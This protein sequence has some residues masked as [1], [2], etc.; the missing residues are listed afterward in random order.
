[1]IRLGGWHDL[2]DFVVVKMGDFD[3]VLGIEYLLGH[4]VIR[5]PL[6][7]CLV[8]TRS[9]PTIV[10]TE[11]HQPNGQTP[12]TLSCNKMPDSLP[13]SLPPRRMIE[14]EI[15]LLS[16]AK[17]PA[18]NAYRMTPPRLAELRKQLDELLNAEFIRPAKALYGAPILFQKKI[19]GS[20]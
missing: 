10:Q 15:E 5:M 20:L 6:A 18:K 8:I 14:H 1:M 2:V 19:D 3:V 16:G 11:I 12:R 4:Q 13:K 9:A 7:K 17:P